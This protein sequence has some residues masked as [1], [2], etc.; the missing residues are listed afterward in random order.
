[1][2]PTHQFWGPHYWL[3]CHAHTQVMLQAI[4]LSTSRIC[5]KPNCI[6]QVGSNNLSQCIH[7]HYTVCF[8]NWQLYVN[9]RL[10]SRKLLIRKLEEIYIH[11]SEGKEVP[12]IVLYLKLKYQIW[13]VYLV[14][15]FILKDS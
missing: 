6:F 12:V 11:Q 9:S 2:L 13:Y 14:L 15:S 8:Y 7:V 10:F 4:V 3:I 1:M 5:K